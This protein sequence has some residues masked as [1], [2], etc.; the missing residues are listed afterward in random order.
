VEI[1]NHVAEFI[2][3]ANET[4]LAE[5]ELIFEFTNQPFSVADFFFWGVLKVSVVFS[6]SSELHIEGVY[7]LFKSILLVDQVSDFFGWILG[8]INVFL[9]LI[10]NHIVQMFDIFFLICDDVL[11]SVGLS[12]ESG[13]EVF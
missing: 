8:Q 13:T 12:F 2:F 1:V 3:L 9:L 4:D 6:S 10:V 11:Q 7:L 5:L